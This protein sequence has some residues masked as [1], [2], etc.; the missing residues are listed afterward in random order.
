MTNAYQTTPRNRVRQ[1]RDNARYDKASVHRIL[2]AGLV[3]QVGFVQEGKPFVIPMIYGRV[4]DSLYLHGARKARI[5][6][7]LASGAPVCVNVTLVDGIVYARSAFNSSMNYRSVVV[8]GTPRLLED[9]AESLNALRT[10]S[11]HTMPGRWDEL[12]APHERELKQTGVIELTI[13]SASAKVAEGPPEDEEEDY[14]TPVWAG[15]VRV[16]TRL[17]AAVPDDRVIEGVEMSPA[18][19]RQTGRRP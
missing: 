1:L 13:E 11:E 17:G 5:V 15:V 7:L 10:I 9:D 4:D 6:K 2:D 16:E 18:A 3:A 12:R 19:A 14:D 8:F